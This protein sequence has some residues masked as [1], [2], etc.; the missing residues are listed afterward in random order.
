MK[1]SNKKIFDKYETNLR[2]A[3]KANYSRNLPKS[4]I[5]E[6]EKAYY[7][8]TGEV[9]HTNYSCGVCILN[10]LKKIARLYYGE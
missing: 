1:S 7:D 9:L 3:F 4:S 2:T 5:Q 6:L 8:E 10:T